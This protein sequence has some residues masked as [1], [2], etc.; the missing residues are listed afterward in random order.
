MGGWHRQYEPDG[1]L[2][3][4]ALRREF[5]ACVFPRRGLVRST[6]FKC[7][8]CRLRFAVPGV[9]KDARSQASAWWRA[10]HPLCVRGEDPVR[11]GACAWRGTRS[12][13]RRSRAPRLCYY[14]LC[15]AAA[16][17]SALNIGTLRDCDHIYLDVGSNVGLQIRKLFEPERY[18]CLRRGNATVCRRDAM[19]RS[20][21]IQPIFDRYFG[22][23]ARQRHSVCAVGFEPNPHFR[24]HLK[25]LAHEYNALGWRTHFFFNAVA[26]ADS[27][28]RF[29]HNEI[30]KPFRH[31]WGAG[32]MRHIKNTRN[33]SNGTWSH[34]RVVDL[35]NWISSYVVTRGSIVMKLDVEGAELQVLPRMIELG[36]IC[37]I[38]YVYVEFHAWAHERTDELKRQIYSDLRKL[39]KSELAH[40]RTCPVVLTTLD[41]ETFTADAATPPTPHSLDV[42]SQLS[43]RG[44]LHETDSN[45][46]SEREM[47]RGRC[48]PAA[49]TAHAFAI[50]L[51]GSSRTDYIWHTLTATAGFPILL[52]PAVDKAEIDTP[53]LAA[54]AAS[55]WERDGHKPLTAGE[56]ACSLSHRMIYDLILL[57]RWPCALIMESDVELGRR[58]KKRLAALPLE[59]LEQ[60][61][62]DVLKL[63]YNNGPA[64]WSDGAQQHVFEG[65]G[66]SA[67]AAYVVSHAGAL[68][69]RAVHTPVWM[70]ADGA[71]D[72]R[73]I[74]HVPN[75][76]RRLGRNHTI[77]LFHANPPM[78]WQNKSLAREKN[79]PLM[80]QA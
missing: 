62:F 4:Q 39:K 13:A 52:M 29:Y 61:R 15:T 27:V 55:F 75:I 48:T 16:S 9:G 3:I 38:Q 34:V 6:A 57:N 42:P 66:G 64:N 74:E 76:L 7:R 32:L 26:A 68:L 71:M 67:T 17:A 60:Q 40:N 37:R 2:G 5:G 77:Q 14:M 69:L 12:P 20:S 54:G 59:R 72:S 58:F 19:N 47:P 10:K 63:E 43:P 8:N 21:P 30:A 33:G 50:A 46:I 24:D 80:P 73:H 11:G 51:R 25:N 36:I 1:E 22:H 28:A 49:L 70:N 31:E 44:T 18:G 45:P 78:A 79:K 65:R 56:F 35:A 41:D 23:E 53:R